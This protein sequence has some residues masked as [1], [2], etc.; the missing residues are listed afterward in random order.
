[1]GEP[2][3]LDRIV[4]RFFPDADETTD[5]LRRDEVQMIY[6]APT[7]EQAS[8]LRQMPGVHTEVNFGP[9][10]EQ[11]TF[12]LDN[13]FLALPEVRQAIAH[14][15]DRATLVQRFIQPLSRRAA[16]FD[17]RVLVTNQAGYEAHGRAYAQRNVH[18]ARARLEQAGFVQGP[19]GVY[20]K[21]GKR[22]SVRLTTTAG[23]KQRE[24][25]VLL[26]HE[27]LAAL[28]IETRID[29]SPAADLFERRLPAGDFD[30]ADFAW[31]G[32]AFPA[33]GARQLYH[34]LSDHN[35]GRYV[36]PSVDA[37]VDDAL[38]NLDEPARLALLNDADEIM[39]QHLPNL[40]L[41][42]RPTLLAYRDGY[43]NV[44]DNPTEGPFWN[45]EEWARQRRDG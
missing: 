45:S 13:E 41:Y 39:W 12:N 9:T 44:I 36:A 32:S 28:G 42:Q 31:V 14:G 35:Y 3:G 7:N 23:H 37:K 29:N 11:L 8:A 2:A 6:P 22:L 30:I 1:L 19:D 4:F 43:T 27:Q 17:N 20:A 10:F 40:P 24:Q 21:D 38:V 25:Q 26:I 18:K 15:V 5:A 34:S 16:Q 33:S